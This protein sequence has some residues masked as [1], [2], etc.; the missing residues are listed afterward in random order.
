MYSNISVLIVW[1]IVQCII[2]NFYQRIAF[3]ACK[4][5]EGY[6][7]Q[8]IIFIGIL[9]T[10]KD[11]EI[12]WDDMFYFIIGNWEILVIQ[13]MTLMQM[14]NFILFFIHKVFLLFFLYLSSA[15]CW[16]ANELTTYEFNI[17]NNDNISEI[18]YCIN[19]ST[20][21][22][23]LFNFLHQKFVNLSRFPIFLMQNE[24]K[25][26]FTFHSLGN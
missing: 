15:F 16:H 12:L 6:K 19:K 3:K 14:L 5:V 25:I 2:I 13:Y 8:Y 20:T 10:I 22:Q 23:L 1:N 18:R 17:M 21:I 26:G 24:M 11:S 7:Y 4:L 9:W